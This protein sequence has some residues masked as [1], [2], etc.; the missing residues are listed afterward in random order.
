M[1]KLD[2][3]FQLQE[4]LTGLPENDIEER[5]LFYSEMIDDRMDE[6]L[7]EEEAV[8]AIGTPEEIAVQIVNETPLARLVKEKIRP[9]RKRKA[10]ETALLIVGSPIWGSLLIAGVA[11]IFSVY[12][13]L[14]A[15]VISLWAVFAALAGCGIGCVAMGCVY[16][17]TGKVSTG[18]AAIAAGLVC[19]GLAILMFY[20]CKAATKGA[21]ILAKKIV[22][23][24]KNC[25]IRKEAA[26]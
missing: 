24:I 7:T 26:K 17:C 4:K 10:W 16:T 22:L 2:F 8:A 21:A 11:V 5:M 25:F 18:I 1:T 9:K 19:A 20:G 15:I 23:G 3:I 13:A 14:W 6:G 12:A